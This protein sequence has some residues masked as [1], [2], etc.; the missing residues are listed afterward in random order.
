MKTSDVLKAARALILDAEHWTKGKYRRFRPDGTPCSYCA[1]GACLQAVDDN[2]DFDMLFDKAVM[3]LADVNEYVDAQ[4]AIV[5]FND[6]FATT[7]ADVLKMFD[8]RIS[9]LEAAGE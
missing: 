2:D 7:H 4:G 3:R 1:V 9:A 5:E 6:D 8:D